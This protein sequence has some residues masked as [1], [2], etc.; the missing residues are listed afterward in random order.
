MNTTRHSIAFDVVGRP[1]QQGSTTSWLDARDGKIKTTSANPGLKPWRALVAGE[2]LAALRARRIW[3]PGP[4]GTPY[5][6]AVVFRM[7]RPKYLAGKATPAHVTTPDVDKLIRAILDAGT[8]IAWADDKQVVEVRARRRWA[9]ADE[10]PGAAIQ[11]AWETT[12]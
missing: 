3:A 9:E 2:F 12:S 6:V 4:P 8:D 11:I 7:P 1:Q 5:T 10:Y